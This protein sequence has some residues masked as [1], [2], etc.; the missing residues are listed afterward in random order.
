MNRW[1]FSVQQRFQHWMKL[2]KGWLLILLLVV[3]GCGETAPSTSLNTS[4]SPTTA[5]T[6]LPEPTATT[7]MIV[8][9]EE[10]ASPISPP[11]DMPEH[12]WEVEIGDKLSAPAVLAGGWVVVASETAVI[13]LDPTTG[14][15]QWRVTPPEGV[16][17]R[18]LATDGEM[19]VVGIPNQ[20]MALR[21]TDGEMLWQQ[22]IEGDLLWPALV[23]ETAVYAGTAYVGPGVIP[24]ADGQASI[25]ALDV[26]SGDILWSQ[27]TEAYS[28]VTPTVSDDTLFVGGSLI[29]EVDVDEGGHLRIHAFA[30]ADGTAQWAF[31]SLDGFIKDLVTDGEQVYFLAYTDMLY[32]LDA[33]NGEEAWR[34]PTENWSPGFSFDN[35]TI[36]MGSDNA[37][38]H[39]IEGDTGTA[40]WRIP[41][42][43]VF[44]APR[45]KPVVQGNFVYFQGNDNQLYCLNRTNGEICWISEPQARSRVALTIGNEQIFL[46]DQDGNLH[47]YGH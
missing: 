41:L 44:N 14:S 17:A 7:E 4:V 28:L 42:E 23:E 6:P 18:S 2:E 24:D 47:G 46:V 21:A 36:Y 40:V 37:F 20:V 16:R 39:A 30:K 26:S 38:V 22:A 43:G 9:E 11:A 32:G 34:Y 29:T 15:E 1:P 35:G 13:A 19:L 5:A 31:N 12:L 25:Y 10:E 8:E 27:K 33:N 45:G 3:V